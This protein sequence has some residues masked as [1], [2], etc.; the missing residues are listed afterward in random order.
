MRER[1]YGRAIIQGRNR[2]GGRNGMRRMT[3]EWKDLLM[4]ENKNGT[5]GEIIKLVSLLPR[6]E[7]KED[8]LGSTRCKLI[9]VWACVC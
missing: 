7:A 3:V 2:E 1:R 4:S 6:R 9:L 8:T 5:G